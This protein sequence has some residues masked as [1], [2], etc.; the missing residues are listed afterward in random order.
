[1][2]QMCLAEDLEL[3]EIMEELGMVKFLVPQVPE[4]E[5]YLPWEETELPQEAEP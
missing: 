5:E 1:M 4:A 2:A 3:Q